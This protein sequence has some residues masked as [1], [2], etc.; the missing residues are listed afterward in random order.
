MDVLSDVIALLRTGRPVSVRLAWRG[1]WGQ[2]FAS[3]P[4]AAGVQV[5]LRGRCWLLPDGADPVPL[6]PGDVLFAPHGRGH[7]LAADPDAPIQ[8]CEPGLPLPSAVDGPDGIVLCGAY[9]LDPRRTHPLLRSL[10]ELVHLP[11]ELTRSPELRATVG[12][13][14]GELERPPRPGGEALVPALLDLLLLYILRTRID[15]DTGPGWAA[16]LRDPAVGAALQA[17]HADPAAPWT[18][19]SLARVAGLSR[20]PFARRFGALAGQPPRTYLTWWRMTTA[21]RLLR[22]DGAPLHAVAARVG[23]TSEFAFA[24]AF[25]RHFGTAPGR[26]RR[27]PTG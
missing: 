23:Y 17:M 8:P 21:A 2:R 26:F 12:L 13:L 9:E 19:A 18:V 11:A 27:A 4:G 22:E 25:K 16:A 7:A 15:E 10:P 1:R 6:A 14:A 5:V 20:A 3:V 24:T